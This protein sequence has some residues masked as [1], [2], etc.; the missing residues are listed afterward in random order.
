ME[1]FFV[2]KSK[3][4]FPNLLLYGLNAYLARNYDIEYS[5]SLP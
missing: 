4:I 2:F 5:S 1:G 3:E